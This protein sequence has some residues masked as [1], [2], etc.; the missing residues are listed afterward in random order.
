M[1]ARSKR[2]NLLASRLSPFRGWLRDQPIWTK[3]GLILIVPTIAAVLVGANSLAQNIAAAGNAE[4]ARQLA[5]VV[6]ASGDLIDGLQHERAGAL[7][8]LGHADGPN[9]QRYRDN[10]TMLNGRVD[11]SI[12][13]YAEQRA[14]LDELPSKVTALLSEIDGSL[15]DLPALRSQVTNRQIRISE[16]T[17]LY[18]RLINDLLDLRDSVMQLTADFGLNQRMRAAAAVSR[19]KENLSQKRIVVHYAFI[20]NAMSPILRNAFIA[21]DQGQ[22]Q[23]VQTFNAVANNAEAELYSQTVSGPDLRE[24]EAYTSWVKTNTS[25]DLR[26]ANFTPDSWEAALVNNSRLIRS[27]EAKLD[28]EVVERASDLRDST[29][30]Q[31]LVETGLLL[32]MLL[33]AILFT[34]RIARS[35]ARA[36][37][38]LREG[39]LAVAQHGLPQAVARLRDP[40]MTTQMSPAQVAS[41]IAEPLPVRSKDEFGQVAEAFN[42]VHLEAV[43]T[44]AEQ[45]ALRASVATMFV[46]LARRSQILV[47][48]LIG[49]LDRLERGEEDPDRL[50]ELFKLDH[51]A[52]RMRRNDENLLVLAGADSTRVQRDPAG[53]T[54]VLRA[55]QSEVEHYT[56]IEFGTVDQDLKITAHAVNDMVHLIAEL[57][58]NA[59]SFSPPESQVVVEARRVGDRAVIYIEDRGIGIGPEQLAELNERL[60]RPP[61]VDV[62]VSRMMGLVVVARLA[63]RHGVKVELRQAPERGTI[64]EVTVPASVLVSRAL[65]DAP[66]RA[67]ARPG[68]AQA[69]LAIGSRPSAPSTS[70][71]PNA[72]ATEPSLPARPFEPVRQPMPAWSD[73]TGATPSVA[74]DASFTPRTANDQTEPL[75]QRRAVEDAMGAGAAGADVTAQIPRQVLRPE[76]SLSD[77]GGWRGAGPAAPVSPM[78]TPP[79]PAPQ[80]TGGSRMGVPPQPMPARPVDAPPA[81]P[82]IPAKSG[83]SPTDS[84]TAT[85]TTPATATPAPASASGQTPS[86]PAA[87]KAAARVNTGSPQVVQPTGVIPA[88]RRGESRTPYVDETME[89]PIF[90]EVESAWFRTRQSVPKEVATVAAPT[91]GDAKAVTDFGRGGGAQQDTPEAVPADGRGARSA[92]PAGNAAMV[93]GS[94]SVGGSNG[95]GPGTGTSTG[96][97]GGVS[98][99]WGSS[100][101]DWRTAADDGWRAASAAAEVPVQET[102]RT[103]LPKR[104]PM[105]QLVPGG[106]DKPTDSTQRRTPEGVRGLLSAYHRGVQRGRANSK[107]EKSGAT[108]AGWQNSQSSFGPT[109]GSGQKEHQG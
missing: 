25:A 24:A 79:T 63:A 3:L 33:L 50:A 35:M 60:A 22:A 1:S 108:P 81:W 91:A 29:W 13:P 43:R 95:I 101:E 31:L 74:A 96:I 18:D 41:Q 89:L 109:A 23:A 61:L 93:G 54:D 32:G 94:M 7:L 27:V 104:V 67:G 51:L 69:A 16:A 66:E 82:P 21:A 98:G 106:V 73:L 8:L 53:L 59:T 92:G 58:D 76:P 39:A 107:D 44:A 2:A 47:D 45:A 46:N 90:R 10:Y 71:R 83:S 48:R 103:G 77:S 86:S 105:A 38:E 65:P 49:H 75:P 68:T 52:T 26:D 14:E 40:D 62:A 11:G 17:H 15:A 4:R 34:W 72:P 64:A 5:S 36:L 28:A 80:Q 87:G 78:P 57:L 9:D 42:A 84:A 97:G 20:Q 6:Q 30:R 70:P 99:G 56:R 55:A 12:K 88:P 37:R 102:T 85:P 100:S 19:A